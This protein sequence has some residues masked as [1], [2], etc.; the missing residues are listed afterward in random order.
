MRFWILIFILFF[1]YE[2]NRGQNAGQAIQ[3]MVIPRADQEPKKPLPIYMGS[4]PMVKDLNVYKNVCL[5]DSNRRLVELPKILPKLLLDIRYA[6]S[7]NFTH[8]KLYNLP[9]AYLL[10]P[11]AYALKKVNEELNAKGLGLIIYDAYRPYSITVKFFDLIQDSN[12]VASPSYGSRHNRGCAIDLGLYNL[13]TGE[14]LEMPTD[15]D[16]FSPLAASNY[17]NLPKQALENRKLLFDIMIKFGFK[18]LRTEWWH[19]DFLT[20]EKLPPIDISF[21]QLEKE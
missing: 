8:T 21:E 4:I 10:S 18:P 5:F 1:N 19:F 9:R 7:Q 6:T 13:K 3:K 17:P 12:Y 2:K 15:F 11:A 20:K 16:S 14:K